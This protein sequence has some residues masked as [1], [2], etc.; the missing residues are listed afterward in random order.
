MATTTATTTAASTTVDAKLLASKS[1]LAS[2]EETFL[3]LLTTQLKNQDPL[4][5]LDSNAFTQQL[6]QMT[7]VEQQ[8]LTNQLLQSMVSQS[9]GT[10]TNAVNYIGK[11]ISAAYDAVTLADGTASWN[12][13]LPANTS[14]AVISIKNGLD[15]TIWTGSTDDLTSGSHTFTWNGKTTDGR[16]LNN[17]GT[18]TL[19]VAAKDAA[20]GDVA[21]PVTVTGKVTAIETVNGET[22]ALIGRTRIPITKITGVTG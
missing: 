19:S 15:Q 9:A 16:Q 14:E 4:S 20:A 1:R 10:M 18:Y 21:V 11:S 6:V 3:A 2:S 8:L 22:Q 13:N 12:Y 7:G 17:G 5:P